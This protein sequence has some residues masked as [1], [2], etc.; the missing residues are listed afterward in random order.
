MLI[1]VKTNGLIFN[2]A[3]DPVSYFSAFAYQE[4]EQSGISR[5][6]YKQFYQ[7]ASRSEA[8]KII[9]YLCKKGKH[10]LKELESED[11]ANGNDA[12]IDKLYPF[13]C[14]KITTI[15]KTLI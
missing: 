6:K 13:H 4:Q 5:T 3:I 10:S 9:K 11:E 15:F 2:G 12:P 14:R 8:I 7:A 1:N